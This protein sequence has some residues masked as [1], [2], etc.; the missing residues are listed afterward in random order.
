MIA[1]R[2]DFMSY[3]L[4]LAKLALGYSSP[5]PAVGAVVVKDGVTVGL[6]Y[7]QEPYAPHA[8][9]MALRQAG[10]KTQGATM[11]VTLEPC[12]HYGK[13][14]PCTKAIIEAGIRKTVTEKNN[15]FCR[16]VEGQLE[17]PLQR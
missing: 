14:P 15:G 6:G 10:D 5:N 4:S 17:C 7:T 1:E 3:A 13:T 9:I 11:Y 8:E 2:A 12:S 16:T